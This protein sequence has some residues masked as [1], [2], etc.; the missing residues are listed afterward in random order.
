[1]GSSATRYLRLAAG[2]G[3]LIGLGLTVGGEADAIGAVDWS[4]AP[5]TLAASIL[6]LGVAPLAQALT[7]GIALRRVG[8]EAPAAATLRVWARSF[9]L[10][11]EPTGA[12]GFVYRV[13]VRE[14]LGATTAQ[15]LTATGYEQLAAVVAGAVVAPV[16]Y[17][18]VDAQPPLLACAL[19]AGA[20]GA[21]LGLR[22]LLASPRLARVLAG[23]GVAVAGPVPGQ[24]LA[25]MVAV[26]WIGW[27]ATG[28]GAWLLA[29]GLLGA[30]SGLPAL[31]L[32]GAFALAWVVGVLVPLLPGGLGPRDAALTVALTPALGP[33][34]AAGLALALRA[35]SLAGELAAA[36]L[37]ETAALVL[38]TG[39]TRRRR[40]L[41][42]S[43]ACPELP[44]AAPPGAG[45]E[46]AIV[47]VPTYDERDALPLFVD[48]FAATAAPAG[49]ELLVVDDGSPDGTGELADALAAG[50]PWLHVLHRL[51]KDGLG[52]AYRAGFGWCLERGYA[53]IGQM[54][55]DL[56]H[57]PEKLGE[58]RTA[59]GAEQAGLVLGSRYAPGG[60]TNGWGRGRL[61]LS[62]VGCW[63]ARAALGLPFSDLSGGFKLWRADTLASIGLERMLSAGYAFQVEATQLAHLGGARIVEVPFVFSERVAGA[64]KMTLAISLEGVRVTLAL[65]RRRRRPGCRLGAAMR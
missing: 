16:A 27:A 2:A 64:S 37:A 48:R 62:R 4:I 28:L 47:V 29:R 44:P 3:L 55:C 40:T 18:A 45:P 50:R 41:A 34:R 17:L 20:A 15:V 6:L 59:L 51:G 21:A 24:T 12:L 61:A 11:Y 57:P 49:F 19:A 56:S 39:R 1:M 33:G 35:V 30:A 32:L 54:D 22:R 31:A 65:R 5:L 36:G 42:G 52:M 9:L 58:M 7:L 43:S 26:D 25:L 60:G 63:A 46:R 14:R 8:A 10:R 53:V 13:R 23:R 38:A